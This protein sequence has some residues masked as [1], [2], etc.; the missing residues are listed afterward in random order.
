ML[1]NSQWMDEKEAT[2]RNQGDGLGERQMVRTGQSNTGKQGEPSG[3][4]EHPHWSQDGGS[5][6]C[7][8]SRLKEGRGGDTNPIQGTRLEPPIPEAYAT[9]ILP[10]TLRHK[11]DTAS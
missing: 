10:T 5:L 4:Q 9:Q 8:G 3:S 1:T 2:P 11:N 7:R 6:K